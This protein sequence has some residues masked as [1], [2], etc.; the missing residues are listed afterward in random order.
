MIGL[1]IKGMI[2]RIFRKKVDLRDRESLNY[3][4]F[5]EGRKNTKFILTPVQI[6]ELQSHYS[7]WDYTLE[8]YTRNIKCVE[9][10]IK[11]K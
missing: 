9:K 6:Y 5:F 4:G 1:K 11:N 10:K 3:N 8:L 7:Y 2:G